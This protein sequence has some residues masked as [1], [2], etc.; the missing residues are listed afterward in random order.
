M[1]LKIADKR[2]GII[3]G[4]LFLVCLV[5]AGVIL[6]RRFSLLWSGAGVIFL[7]LGTAAMILTGF[8]WPEIRTG[9]KWFAGLS[10]SR[11][12]LA[13]LPR[14][15]EA[16]GRDFWLLGVLGAIINFVLALSQAGESGSGIQA[17]A[18]GMALSFR[19]ALYGMI[20][21]VICAVPAIKAKEEQAGMSLTE[22]AAA[23]EGGPEPRPAGL[24]GGHFIGYLL[25]LGVMAWAM[26]PSFGRWKVAPWPGNP[27]L[28][29]ASLLVVGGGAA[30]LF[31]FLGSGAA[32]KSISIVFG[33]IGVAGAM[34]GFLQALFG[35]A[36][37]DIAQVSSA[38]TFVVSSC[39]LALLGIV[40]IGAPRED[41]RPRGLELRAST[42]RR[43]AWYAF[44]LLILIFLI[45]VLLLVVTPIKIHK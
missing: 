32:G 9:L 26:S 42:M 38:L 22:T 12:Q 39:F 29:W 30:L 7:F 3:V 25:L 41:R 23:P 10:V 33:T 4:R 45:I 2:F 13:L 43:L 1:T 35:F 15:W 31:L 17:I 11:D 34:I 24:G 16:V 5:V 20:M 40:L 14:F 28:D 21:A 44:P 8:S 18:S 36:R 6:S 19:T 37:T 27:F